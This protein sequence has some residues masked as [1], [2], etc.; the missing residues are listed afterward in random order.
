MSNVSCLFVLGAVDTDVV[1]A[2]AWS[3]DCQLISCADDK[4]LC[5]WGPDGDM[6]GKITTVASYVTSISWLPVVGKQV[7]VAVSN[8]FL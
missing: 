2:V 3:P 8:Y 5:K 6:L 4:V 1:S 7:G